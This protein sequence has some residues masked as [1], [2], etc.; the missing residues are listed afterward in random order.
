MRSRNEVVDRIAKRAITFNDEQVDGIMEDFQDI[1]LDPWDCLY[2]AIFSGDN[3]R[4][5]CVKWSDKGYR[6]V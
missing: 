1:E 5:R 4:V 3:E 2:V 6:G